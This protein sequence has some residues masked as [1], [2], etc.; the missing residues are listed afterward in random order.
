MLFLARWRD[1]R[2]S[3]EGSVAQPN[4]VNYR[5]SF[6][7]GTV[8]VTALAFRALPDVSSEGTAL[9]GNESAHHFVC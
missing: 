1:S 5:G 9:D 6:S 2:D 4:P 8:K 3:P 7:S